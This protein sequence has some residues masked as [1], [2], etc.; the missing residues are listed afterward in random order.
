MKS[1]A[2][3]LAVLLAH[4]SYE[5]FASTANEA[6]WMFYALRGVEGV[7][8]CWLLLPVFQIMQG[9][10]KFVGI[11]AV[12]LGALE[13]GQTALCGYVGQGMEVPLGS[14]LCFER[15]GVIPHLALCALALTLMI[16]GITR[17][18]KP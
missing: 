1:I 10:Q 15:F 13:E 4:Y 3:L 7:V 8:F 18:A 17:N 5:W 11:F 2:A 9:W 16:K 6:A 14:A 12:V